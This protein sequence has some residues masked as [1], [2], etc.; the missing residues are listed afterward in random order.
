GGFVAARHG[1][2]AGFSPAD[3]ALHRFAW[4]GFVFLPYVGRASL[5]GA[6]GWIKAIVLTFF[7]GPPLALLSYAG[8]LFVPLGHGGVIQPSSAALGGL[9]LATLV[10][11]EKLP[12]QRALGAAV[13]VAG[14][15]VIGGEALAAIGTH[16]VVGDL[17]F[18]CAGLMFATFA[19]LL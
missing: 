10:L 1:I 16:G 7:G 11:R 19:L 9:M 14:L 4:A 8:F 12:R 15:C 5:G 2:A 13:I 17:M 18:M 3:I 6:G